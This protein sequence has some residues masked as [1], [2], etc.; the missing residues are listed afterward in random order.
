VQTSS[1]DS[2]LTVNGS[3]D[4]IPRNTGDIA[5]ENIMTVESITGSPG[6]QDLLIHVNGSWNL[7]L[8]AYGMV[9]QYDTSQ[10]EIDS[11]SLDGTVGEEEL[12]VTNYGWRGYLKAAAALWYKIPP[13]SGALFRVMVNIKETAPLGESDLTLFNHPGPP[14]AMCD[15]A[16]SDGNNDILP[17]LIH[18][19]VTIE[20]ICGDAN[21][22][23]LVTIADVVYLVNYLFMNG[24]PP[25]PAVCIGD[26]EGD[27]RTSIEDVVYLIGYILQSSTPPVDDCC[28]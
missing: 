28:W 21:A 7:E 6:M 14:P 27:G 12:L 25:L 2:A 3:R 5:L 8:G 19:T 10:I 1:P 4:D 15:Y 9:I 22:D 13:D 11:I 17:I 18:G 23:G 24:P 20:W 16:S 26:A